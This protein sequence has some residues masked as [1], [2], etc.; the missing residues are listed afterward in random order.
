MRAPCVPVPV[1]SL[2]EPVGEQVRRVRAH[3]GAV[4][5]AVTRCPGAS[6][7]LPLL[8]RWLALTTNARAGGVLLERL[9]DRRPVARCAVAAVDERDRVQ[10][11]RRADRRDAGRLV[12]DAD[13]DRVGAERV[14]LA[15]P[16]IDVDEGVR[17]RRGRL[18]EPVDEELDRAV[19]AVA[20]VLDLADR[21]SRRRPYR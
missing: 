5:L 15:R 9:G 4:R 18:V 17:A 12:E 3:G 21:R 6:Q 8:L 10:R 20:V 16:C 14:H 11:R 1:G 19:G 7:A 13:L 2:C